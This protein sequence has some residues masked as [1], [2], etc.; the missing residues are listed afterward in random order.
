MHQIL[1]VEIFFDNNRICSHIRSN[2]KHGHTTLEAHLAPQHLAI[3]SRSAENFLA[4]SKTV[5]IETE[6]LVQRML[7]EAKHQELAYRSIL[8]LQRL[9]KKFTS[10]RLERAAK[11]AN[12]ARITCQSFV[13]VLIQD[14]LRDLQNAPEEP[15]NLIHENIRGGS[16]FH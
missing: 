8:E 7:E 11:K 13:R 3:K 12:Q 15:S 6:E 10:P 9:E 5:G 1:L 14:E 4:W 2:K 16:Y